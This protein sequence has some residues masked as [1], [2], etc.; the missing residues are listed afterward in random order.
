MHLRQFARQRNPPVAERFIQIAERRRTLVRRF[1]KDHR[2]ALVG[3]LSQML[4]AAFFV[5]A[6]KALER[7]PS[8]RQAG[9]RQRRH[10]RARPRHRQH[11]NAALRALGHQLLAGI[12][13]GGH[14]RIRNQHAVF[15]RFDARADL[16]SALAFIVFIV[17]DQRLFDPEMVEQAERHPRVLRR[18]KIRLLQRLHRARREIPQIPDRRPHYRQCPA[19]AQHP[20]YLYFP[21]RRYF[22]W[23][24]GADSSYSSFFIRSVYSQNLL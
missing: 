14:S 20:F 16:L 4:P 18:D 2:A 6:Q 1:V 3:E 5:H 11:R 17:A 15:A 22:L 23:K 21:P 13:D 12:R 19:H 10:H 7:K 24:N 9:K 8:R